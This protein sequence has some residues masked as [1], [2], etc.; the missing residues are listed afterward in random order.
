MSVTFSSPAVTPPCSTL[1]RASPREEHSPVFTRSVRMSTAPSVKSASVSSVTGM[2]SASPPPPKSALASASA[3]FAASSP[4]TIFVSSK[5]KISLARLRSLPVHLSIS[6][7]CSSGR[8]VS[9]RMHFM[10]SASPTLRQ[11]W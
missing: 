10:T 4:W 5:A 1:R 7:I 6:S 2:F 8:K 11:Y 3:F 9:I